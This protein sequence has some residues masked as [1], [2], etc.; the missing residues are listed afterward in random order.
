MKKRFSK[1]LILASII[2]ILS[3]SMVCL[4]ATDM[5]QFFYDFDFAVVGSTEF[6][7]NNQYTYC[8]SSARSYREGNLYGSNYHYMIALDG[9]GWFKPNYEGSYKAADGTEK[10]TYYNGSSKIKANTYTVNVDTSDYLTSAGVRIIGD[11]T[12]YQY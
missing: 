2:L 8:K 3:G 9:N 10:Y 6:D 1:T 11:G 12:L 7:L 5:G 4:A